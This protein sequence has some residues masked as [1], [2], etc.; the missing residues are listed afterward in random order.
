VLP[1]WGH[2]ASEWGKTG[3]RSLISVI[4]WPTAQG[5]QVLGTS[6]ARDRLCPRASFTFC[7]QAAIAGTTFANCAR[8]NKHTAIC[9]PRS[10]KPTAR[11]TR[12]PA[13]NERS[14]VHRRAGA[15]TMWA[16]E[17][18]R[19]A[20]TT[21]SSKR[22]C[23]PAWGPNADRRP[24]CLIDLASVG[25]MFGAD[26]QRIGSQGAVSAVELLPATFGKCAVA[27]KAASHQVSCWLLLRCAA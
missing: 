16:E 3:C 27:G 24:N 12:L 13:M 22:N 21:R 9:R 10:R 19:T 11:R 25:S 18:P 1:R 4:G 2:L 15:K 14:A 7:F 20:S 6:R 5:P 23:Y 17:S 8:P 26:S